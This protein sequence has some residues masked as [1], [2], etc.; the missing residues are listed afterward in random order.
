MGAEW[1]M[2]KVQNWKRKI[3]NK[4]I[5]QINNKLIYVKSAELKEKLLI[6]IDLK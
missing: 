5:F 6:R 2:L 3:L 4:N 1:Y